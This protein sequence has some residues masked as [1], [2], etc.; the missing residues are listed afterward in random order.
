MIELQN[1]KKKI[2]FP[3]VQFTFNPKIK[4]LAIVLIVLLSA[5]AL[6][7]NFKSLLIAAMVNGKPISR[8][9]LDRQ[10]EKQGGK[11][12]L[13]NEI[14]KM[15]ILDEAKNKK[16]EV[17]SDEVDKKI[18]E[19]EGQVTAGGSSLDKLLEA[20]GQ[21]RNG[22]KEQIKVQLIIEKALSKDI[23]ISDQEI[24]DYYD[25]NKASFAKDSKFN[26]LKEQIK[27]DLVQ[28][29]I[30]EKFQPWLDELKKKAKV[31]YFVNL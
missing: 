22:L 6:F 10:L 30:G 9:Y 12:V 13:E 27:G 1:M 11:Q 4:K 14:V 25:K 8:M 19:I 15:L 3:K 7:F 17:T 26:D 21:T 23:S 20:Q 18:Q 31:Y 28:Q 5:G 24:K 16:I 2:K 29:K